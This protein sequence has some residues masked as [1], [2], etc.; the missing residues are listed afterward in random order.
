MVGMG[1]YVTC[2]VLTSQAHVSLLTGFSLI[3]RG[4]MKTPAYP[5]RNCTILPFLDQA[6]HFG[7]V[8]GEPSDLLSTLITRGASFCGGFAT[9]QTLKSPLAAKVASISDFCLDEDACHANEIIADG[10]REVDMV[11]KMLN[12]G[13]SVAS[14]MEPF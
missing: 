9:L 11:C 5:S 10:P 3:T 7:S 4:K 12:V 13:C 2:F 6:I 1:S 14:I 8:A